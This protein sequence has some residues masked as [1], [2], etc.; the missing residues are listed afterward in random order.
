MDYS[1]PVLLALTQVLSLNNSTEYSAFD[2]LRTPLV[3]IATSIFISMLLQLISLL[4]QFAL[5]N[6]I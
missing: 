5:L 4:L 3:I 1:S 2:L 6:R